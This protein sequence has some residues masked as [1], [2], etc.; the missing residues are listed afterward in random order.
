LAQIA[1]GFQ[2]RLLIFRRFRLRFLFGLFHGRRV[3][4][5]PK[6]VKISV[7]IPAYNA[8]LSI[9]KALQ[10]VLSQRGPA[11][12]VLIGDDASKDNTRK[13]LKSYSGDPRVK[14]FIFRKNQ[15]P[16][17]TRNKL[18]ARARGKYISFCDADD[19]MLPG[20]L[21][22][23][24][25]ILDRNPSVGVAYGD[26]WLQPKRG[27]AS[28]KRRFTAGSWDLMGG[29]FANGGTMIRK[30]LFKKAGGF[31]PEHTLL[32]DCELFLRLSELTH[33]FYR[34]GKPLYVQNKISGSFSDQPPKKIKKISKGLL[35]DAIQRRY[36]FQIKW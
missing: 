21:A 26:L 10:S 12:E 25:K 27:K 28:I 16:G 20:N 18:A 15:G 4:V 2:T 17:V 11:F 32:E 8:A 34:P 14:I 1:G 24:S 23:F 5:K 9:E 6:P 31:K 13:C 35:R 29:C 36:D 19:R 7:I 3:A 33:F 22:A 30:S